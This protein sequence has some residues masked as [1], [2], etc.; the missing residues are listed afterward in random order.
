MKT[1]DMKTNDMRTRDMTEKQFLWMIKLIFV[2]GVCCFGLFYDYAVLLAGTICGLVLM[3]ALY[4][5]GAVRLV[6]NSMSIAL[7]VMAVAS[8]GTCF[9]GIDKGFSWIGLLR[10]LVLLLFSILCMKLSAEHRKAVSRYAVHIG[11]VMTVLCCVFYVTPWRD[12]FW[13]AGRLG[14]FFQ[15]S[16]TCALF[17]LV[18]MV[19][20][21]E[22]SEEFDKGKDK[23]LTLVRIGILSLGIMLTGSRSVFLL[24][25]ATIIFLIVKRRNLRIPLAIMV[26]G[27]VYVGI[28]GSYQNVGRF[29]TI[30]T[31]SSTFLG[32]ILYWKD[33][34]SMVAEYPLGSGYRGYS[35]LQTSMQTGVY[36]T[37]FVHNDFLQIFL[38]TGWIPG[39]IFLFAVGKEIFSKKS[40]VFRRWTIIIMSLH[41]LVDFDMQ[42]VSVFLLFL[43]QFS[44]EEG[45]E[46][47]VAMAAKVRKATNVKKTA[48]TKKAI[49]LK[50]VGIPIGMVTAVCLYFGIADFAAFMEWDDASMAMYPY[51]TEI[52][53]K[54]LDKAES[55]EEA[56]GVAD[57]I[58]K[59]NKNIALCYDAKALIAVLENDYDKMIEHKENALKHGKYQLFEYV[60]YLNLLK[61]SLSYYE[62][63][64]NGQA[65]E[66]SKKLMKEMPGRLTEIKDKTD[67]LGWKIKDKP[68]LDLS[69]EILEYLEEL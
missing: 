12:Y 52:L 63:T 9:Y 61:R 45:K 69:E 26:V 39:C 22:R 16:N 57:K 51:Q 42:Y 53:T 29:L 64:G 17:F 14:G 46:L 66:K 13:Q 60:D 36:T 28:S 35:F 33:G 67:A 24:F 25:I 41:F 5:R 65:Y 43:L 55:M 58:L 47:Q 19:L 21:G 27:I 18:G 20:E 68:E 2:L 11:V 48:K 38:D 4:K 10:S 23:L 15:Y 8:L 3:W 37:R 40:D 54:R 34:L 30:S 7:T 50:M 31:G 56:R 32:R 59:Q 44:W 6:G 49:S 1:N 62:Q